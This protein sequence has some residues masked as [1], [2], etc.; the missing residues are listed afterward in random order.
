MTAERP[1]DYRD[2]VHP[3]RMATRIFI[4]ARHPP[5]IRLRD[6]VARP[7]GRDYHT[8]RLDD[9]DGL[10]LPARWV[11]AVVLCP[12][13]TTEDLVRWMARRG[14]DPARLLFVVFPGTSTVAAFRAWYGA[15]HGDP[16]VVEARTLK[17]FA[18]HLGQFVN[19]WIYADAKGTGWPV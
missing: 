9:L 3:A 10:D 15:G 7:K 5:C 11:L 8:A 2:V 17:G 18:R 19:D 16:L 14:A 13:D 6:E 4:V 12:G 1:A